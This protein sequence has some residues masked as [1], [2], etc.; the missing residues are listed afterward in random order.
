LVCR[1][2]T[3]EKFTRSF[4]RDEFLHYANAP[5]TGRFDPSPVNAQYLVE[6]LSKLGIR[7]PLTH[8][9][10]EWLLQNRPEEAWHWDLLSDMRPE[11]L[12]YAE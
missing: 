3:E 7:P 10:R 4:G 12:H 5:C 8:G 2:A 1:L 9:E 11:H 6:S